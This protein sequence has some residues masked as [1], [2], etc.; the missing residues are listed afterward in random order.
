MLMQKHAAAFIVFLKRLFTSLFSAPAAQKENRALMEIQQRLNSVSPSFCL[1]KWLQVSLHLTTGRTH[2]CYHPPAHAIDPGRLEGNPSAL[3][4]TEQKKRERE[5]MMK[6]ERPKGC[7]YCWRIE[8]SGAHFSDRHYRSLEPWAAER[9]KEIAARGAAAEDIVP[10]YVE[11]NFNQAC[12]FKCSY[13]SPHL[14][15]TWMDEIQKFG[16]YPTTVPHNDIKSLKEQSL[17]PIPLQEPNPYVKA[18]WKWWPSLYPKLKVFRLTGG[19]PLIDHN[20][21]RVLDYIEKHANKDLELAVTTNLCPPAKM[22]DRFIRQ[23][24]RIMKEKRIFRFML[25]PSIDSYGPQAEYIRFGLRQKDFDFNLQKFL[26]DV[27]EALVS[28]IITVNALSPFNILT[29]LKKILAWQMEF[30]Y[31]GGGHGCRRIFLDL[32]Y[33]RFPAWQALQTLPK[34]KA[35]PYL[36]AALKFM[37]ENVCAPEKGQ[38]HGFSP[39]QIHKMRRLLDIVRQPVRQDQQTENRINFYKFFKAHDARRGTDFMQ[40]FPELKGFWRHCRSLAENR[41]KAAQQMSEK[42]SRKEAADGQKG[43]G[44]QP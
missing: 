18:F 39:F 10:S 1:A 35:L 16:P 21:F 4:N 6:G 23:L 22:R 44:M 26:T 24:Q 27:P 34:E 36:D 13:C 2:S 8:D 5:M 37:E 7:S 29:L 38:Y 25:F 41:E 9:F 33:L 12:Q 11:V 19:E 28:F 40:S 30:N 31:Y 32:P 42:E 3:H 43:Q 15:S 14:S 20:T 17:W